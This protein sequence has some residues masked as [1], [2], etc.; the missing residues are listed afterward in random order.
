MRHSELA[1]VIRI[2]RASA[3]QK[4]SELADELGISRSTLTRIERGGVPS[5]LVARVIADWLGTSPDIV[6]TAAESASKEEA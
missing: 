3:Q 2:K 5:P 4:Q 1:R 6:I